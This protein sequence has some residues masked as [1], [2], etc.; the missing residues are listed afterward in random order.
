MVESIADNEVVRDS[1]ADEVGFEGSDTT[2]LFVEEYA[3]A[4]RGAVLGLQ[5]FEDTAERGA[6]VQDVVDDEDVLPREVGF[7]QP[8]KIS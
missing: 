4:K 8:G 1:E 3:G 2:A 7:A 5:K 6:G